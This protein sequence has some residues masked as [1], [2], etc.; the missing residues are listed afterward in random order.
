[1]GARTLLAAF[2][3][4]FWILSGPGAF[5]LGRDL[6]ISLI[7]HV[8]TLWETLYLSLYSSLSWTRSERSAWTG[9]GKN[10]AVRIVAFCE[11]SAVGVPW[12]VLLKG[13]SWG[14]FFS[15]PAFSLDYFE[16]RQRSPFLSFLFD[17]CATKSLNAWLAS[18]LSCCLSLFLR[19]AASS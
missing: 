5:R 12:A 14:S 8:E 13:G 7:S 19:W 18:F 3:T 9:G 4:S 1:M 2:R 6:S 11:K 15:F 16:S 10:L 17:V